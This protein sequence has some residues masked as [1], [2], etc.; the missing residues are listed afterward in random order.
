[1]E[2]IT[3]SKKQ[4]LEFGRRIAKKLK[5]GDVV[6]LYGDLGAGKTTLINGIAKEFGIKQPITSPT[7]ILMKNYRL[8]VT[9]YG[10]R[11]TDLIHIDAYRI[12]YPKE[13]FDI[14]FREFLHDPRAVIIIEWADKIK[15]ILPRRRVDIFLKTVGENEREIKLVRVK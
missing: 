13:I 5:G 7:F 10:L 1:M 4:T 3:H 11:V 15:K 14:G 8:G 12:R 2:I 6:C 9:R